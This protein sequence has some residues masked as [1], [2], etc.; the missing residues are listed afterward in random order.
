V[1][2]QLLEFAFV[3]VFNPGILIAEQLKTGIGAHTANRLRNASPTGGTEQ[4]E[5]KI[6]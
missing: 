5:F 1:G 2:D 4:D 6:V 3:E